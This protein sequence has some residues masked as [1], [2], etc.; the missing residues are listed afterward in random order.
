MKAAIIKAL[1]YLMTNEKARKVILVV[2]VIAFLVFVV[3]PVVV[4]A[5]AISA[6]GTAIKEAVEFITDTSPEALDADSFLAAFDNGYSM[7]KGD[8]LDMKITEANLRYLLQKVHDYNHAGEQQREITV[9]GKREYV[10]IDRSSYVGEDG[11]THTS[12]TI[13]PHTDYPEKKITVSNNYYEGL[14][15]LDFRLLYYGCVLSTIER[16]VSSVAFANTIPK[17]KNLQPIT[18]WEDDVDTYFGYMIT[19]KDIDTVF[20]FLTIDYNYYFDVLRDKKDYYSYDECCTLPHTEHKWGAGPRT[21]IGETIYNY[22][23]SYL[24]TGVGKFSEIESTINSDSIL[25][26]TKAIFKFN[27]LKQSFQQIYKDFKWSD[28]KELFELMPGG[29]N[30]LTRFEEWDKAS[31]SP[32]KT[33]TGL[34]VILNPSWVQLSMAGDYLEYNTGVSNEY[35]EVLTYLWNY[36]INQMGYSKATAA[37]ICGNAMQECGFNYLAGKNGGAAGLF[38]WMGGRRTNLMKMSDPWTLETQLEFFKIEIQSSYGSSLNTYSQKYFGKSFSQLTDPEQ[39]AEAFCVAYEGCEYN[40]AKGYGKGSSPEASTMASNGKRYQELKLR[41]EYAKS[42]YSSMSVVANAGYTYDGTDLPYYAQAGQPWS[43]ISLG[44]GTIKNRG[45]SLCSAAMAATYCKNRV[46]TPAD[47]AAI[48]EVYKWTSSHK[49]M[50]HE[51]SQIALRSLGVSFNTLSSDTATMKQQITK[52]LIQH[53]PVIL[54]V[55]TGYYHFTNNTHYIVLR[56]M[57]S[58]GGVYL[59]NPN[60]AFAAQSTQR[61]NLDKIL[62]QLNNRSGCIVCIPDT[63]STR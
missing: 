34:K 31:Y 26:S 62:G 51:P 47:I 60:P 40:L 3:A 21:V 6:I 49:A 33:A 23:S 25:T 22:P 56:Y 63:R 1:K 35:Q 54:S 36:L 53:H 32:Y 30:L 8:E 27:S 42:I 16:N 58:S 13:T 48:N 20:S 7:D 11:K 41:K 59:H 28:A 57:D 61:F 4:G 43:Q 46:I 38:Q 14:D 52:A 9:Q 50:N 55:K 29:K 17:D 19:K 15:Y 24:L 10:T 2:L 44:I 37:G 18:E 12:I 5:T 45:C 39:A